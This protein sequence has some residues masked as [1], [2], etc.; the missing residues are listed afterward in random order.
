MDQDTTRRKGAHVSLLE[1]VADR[2]CDILIGTQ[3]V[4]KGLDFP[5]V[6][7]VGVLQAD[8]GLHLP[9][10]RSSEKTFQLLSQVAGRAGRGDNLG[11]VVI[12]THFPDDP[13]ILAAR[14]HACEDFYEQELEHRRSLGYPPFGRLLRV[15]VDGQDERAARETIMALAGAIGRDL[16]HDT[17]MLGPSPAVIARIKNAYRFTLLVQSR[18]AAGVRACLRRIGSMPR[19]AREGCRIA[20]D[21]DPVHML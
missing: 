3:M 20:L 1:A 19:R 7:L 16:P 8:I 21:V 17:R 2:T 14:E 4:A 13:A 18:S 15:L 10:F 11:E 12:Q 6:A 5:G 9:D